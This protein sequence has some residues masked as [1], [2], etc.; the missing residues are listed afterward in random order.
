MARLS[1]PFG[2][3]DTVDEFPKPRTYAFHPIEFKEPTWLR[4]NSLTVSSRL[5]I[6]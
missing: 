5:D 6:L 1:C 3:R 4:L 2:E